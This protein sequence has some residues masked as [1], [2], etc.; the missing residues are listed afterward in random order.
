MLKGLKGK[1][2]L[3]TGAAGGIGRATCRRL[4]E[5]GARVVAAT[6]RERPELAAE[7]GDNGFCVVTDVT[8]PESM[9]NAVAQGADRYGG[10]D[11]AF[12]NAGV[13]NRAATV[14]NFSRAEYERVFNVNV[15]GVFLGAQAVVN[16]MIAAEKPGGILFMSS[17]A[18]LQGIPF[19]SVYCG[20][21][22]AVIGIAKTLAHEVASNGIR[23]NVICPGMVES[24]MA[25]SIE[26]SLAEATGADL[27]SV[28]SDVVGE[29]ELGR[30]ATVEEVAAMSAWILSDEAPYSHGEIFTLTGGA[31]A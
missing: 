15:L 5:E 7:L 20:S 22:W 8:D 16:H 6:H 9:A 29:Y 4:I 2:V 13:E 10:I 23:V 1:T 26:D 14:A 27:E 28:H 31:R 30:Y 25:H 17:I 12:L 11:L 18:G 21:K 24:R 3:V 19:T